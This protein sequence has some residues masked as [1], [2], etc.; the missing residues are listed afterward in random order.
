MCFVR[1]GIMNFWLEEHVM[2]VCDVHSA[3][4]SF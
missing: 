3:Y 1:F 2:H 4:Q